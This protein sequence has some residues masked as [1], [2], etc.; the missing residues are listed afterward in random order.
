MTTAEAIP[1]VTA[2]ISGI[3]GGVLVAVVNHLL[4]RNKSAAE[5]EKL[6]AETD[7][8][9]AETGKLT[10]ELEG[11]TA[12]VNY[13]LAATRE[14]TLYDSAAGINLHD[15]N[16]IEGRSW[17][18][19]EGRTTGEKGTGSLSIL[20]GN[21]LNIQRTNTDGRFEVW[22]DRYQYD[23][24]ERTVIPINE[25][26]AG[27]RKLRVSFEAKAVDAIHHL[28]IVLKDAK[29]G[30]TPFLK[31]VIVNRNEWT[32]FDL[33]F[34]VSPRLDLLMRL[35]DTRITRAP[36]SLQIKNL[37]VAERIG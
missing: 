25:M 28:D 11:L 19:A 13:Q 9:R 26:I 4:S 15:F 34:Q 30:A 37:V 3:L 16:S 23:N 1:I 18:Q 29:T 7:K 12:T 22:L 17:N 31:S 24:K 33:Y 8:I 10:N 27:N 35:Y 21:V 20:D 32:P 36:S 2:L 6:R 14:Q 5:I